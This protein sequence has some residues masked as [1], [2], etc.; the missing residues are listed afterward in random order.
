MI[1]TRHTTVPSDRVTEPTPAKP[2]TVETRRPDLAEAYRRLWCAATASGR[3]RI[4]SPQVAKRDLFAWFG[5][6]CAVDEAI[7]ALVEAGLAQWLTPTAPGTRGRQLELPWPPQ[8]VSS[9]LLAS[10]HQ[11]PLAA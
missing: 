7:E 9:Y 10:S 6:T 2:E 11:L 8:E 5:H 4:I 3:G 1:R